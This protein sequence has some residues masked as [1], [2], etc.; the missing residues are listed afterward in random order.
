MVIK[1]VNKTI[2]TKRS[3]KQEAD[4]TNF[5]SP[6]T[7]DNHSSKKSELMRQI[8]FPPLPKKDQIGNFR[9]EKNRRP[10]FHLPRQTQHNLT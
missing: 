5:P 8:R 10:L 4:D 2:I 3:K 6:I 7:V 9:K 1:I